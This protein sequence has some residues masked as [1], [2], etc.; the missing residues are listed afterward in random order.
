M[1]YMPGAGGLLGTLYLSDK[2][3]R[4][5]SE[6]AILPRDIAINQMLRPDTAKYDARRFNWI[7][8]LSSY[9]RRHVRGEP[10]GVK[11]AE[12]CAASKSSRD[13][14]HDHRNLHYADAAQRLGRHKFRLVTGYRGGPDVDLAVERGEVDGRNVVVDAAQ[15]PACALAFR[16]TVVI[17]FKPASKSHPELAGVPLIASARVERG[18]PPHLRIPEFR[19]RHRLERGG[20]AQCAARPRGVAAAG[21]RQ[22]GGRPGIPCRRAQARA[23]NHAGERAR[24][25][26]T[27]SHAPLRR[28][29]PLW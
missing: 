15:D 6:L 18:R 17:P 3:A 8:T 24:A 7:G 25:G 11:T 22:N 10:H 4:D 14:G 16:R 19:R 1:Q 27:S 2:A 20:A 13:R 12:I 26:R 29:R 28:Q 23:R 5:G 9:A 21:L